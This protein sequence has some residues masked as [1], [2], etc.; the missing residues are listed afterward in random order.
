MGEGSKVEPGGTI[1]WMAK[2]T[3]AANLLMVVILVGGLMGILRIKQEVFPEFDLDMINVSIP[4]PGASPAEVEQGVVLAVEEAVHALDGVK[5][6]TSNSSDGVGSVT[7]ELLIDADPDKALADV[8]AAIDRIR[9]FPEESEKANVSLASRRSSVVS[10]VISGEQELR[11]LHDIAEKARTELLDHDDITQVEILGVPPLELSV[12]IEREVLESHGLTL[13][14]VAARV[15][16]SSLEMPGGEIET[17]AGEILVRVADRRVL[18]HEFE[19]II[20]AST[21]EGSSLLLG[22]IATITD[23]YV[24]TDQSSFYNGVPAVRVTAFRVGDETPKKVSKAVRGYSKELR[25]E[26]PDNIALDIWGDRSEILQGRIDL[27]LKNAFLG[28]LF[29][30]VVLSLFLDVGLAFWVSLGI[31]ISFFGAFLLMPGA[32]QS[33]NMLTLFA[34]IITIGIVVD[35]AIIVGENT[36]EK[37]SKGMPLLDAAISGAQEMAVPVTFS[38]LT[39]VAA[40]APL[41]FI[42]GTMGK[43]MWSIPVIVISVLSFSLIESFYILPAHLSHRRWLSDTKVFQLVNVPRHYASRGL[44]WFT[45]NVYKRVLILALG[46]RR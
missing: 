45:G 8:K 30:V 36:Y 28:F 2:N 32:D 16:A 35:D 33:I 19:D 13:N 7:V 14:D 10:L 26:L 41:L 11:V 44:E 21:D 5:R 20:V 25:Q 12:E 22:D 27:L 43:V 31:P 40:F 9:S 37:S 29:V 17:K 4:Y 46:Q 38:I 24:D 39:T 1:A 23:G 34:L 6:V 3:V 18:A 42:P 15:A